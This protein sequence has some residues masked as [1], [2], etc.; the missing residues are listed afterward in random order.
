[1]K[2]I[3]LALLLVFI[4]GTGDWGLGTFIYAQNETIT[5]LTYYPAPY[6]V[7]QNLNVMGSVCIG[8]TSQ[9][10]KL[11]IVGP[12]GDYLGFNLDSYSSTERWHGVFIQG[13]RA[14]GTATSPAAVTSGDRILSL[15]GW[16][17]DGSAFRA[18]GGINIYVDG[19]VT[20][21]N[22]P[23]R[24]SFLTV[25]EGEA[26]EKERM[27][28]TNEGNV[29]IGD[30]DS[31]PY[32][33]IYATCPSTSTGS[34]I[35]VK[36]D[37]IISSLTIN[38]GEPDKNTSLQLQRSTITGTS[39]LYSYLDLTV[40]SVGAKIGS[41][42]NNLYLLSGSGSVCIGTGSSIEKL[43]INGSYNGNL[44]IQIQNTD[45]GV[46]SG[47]VIKFKGEAGGE[48]AFIAVYNNNDT[49][50]PSH[51]KIVNETINALI[52]FNIGGVGTGTEKVRI[53][54]NGDVGIGTVNPGAKL[55]VNG[56]IKAQMKT[57]YSSPNYKYMRWIGEGSV[58]AHDGIYELG[59]DIAELFNTNEEVEPG[60]V[61]VIDS[62]GKLKKSDKP[63]V[64]KVAGIV[65]TAPAILFEGSELQIA[66]EPHKFEKGTN[67]PVT[68]A[69][70][71][72]AN[73]SAENGPIEPG[74]LLTTSPT[75]GHA[76]KAKPIDEINGYPIY[77]QGCIVGKALEPLKEGKGK[78]LVLV[79]LM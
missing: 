61:L 30:I 24:I 49:F 36:D 32:M 25:K 4:L 7:Y 14:R 47:E 33:E 52:T 37:A 69:G 56:N 6:G 59:Y 74:D 71:V 50:R 54:N 35:T 64:T 17:Y 19:A 8:T 58:P 60:D 38:R 75:P 44:G 43:N 26:G 11:H 31:T 2:R 67:P 34:T 10:G 13:R 46:Y 66:P 18:M 77:P 62:N 57:L 15:R 55:H 42:G 23:S 65:S 53:A 40:D 12:D 76:M 29:T 70:R 22:V 73:V 16:G 68:L 45:T 39:T 79:C 51:M 78:I 21:N 48:S 41:T 1:M 9:E 20:S 5:L 28:I 63:Y 72:L 3:G 27:R